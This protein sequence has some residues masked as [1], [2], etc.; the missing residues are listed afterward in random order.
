M[1]C[2][3]SGSGYEPI[4][5]MLT[6]RTSMTLPVR[7]DESIYGHIRFRLRG[8]EHPERQ[9]IRIAGQDLR[10][11]KDGLVET[12]VPLEEQQ[13]AYS[14]EVNGKVLTDSVYTPCGENDIIMME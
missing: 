13:T 12:Y 4:D 6:L 5:T 1:Q 7:R 10:A 9:T 14:V 8:T 2:T 3:F 11:D